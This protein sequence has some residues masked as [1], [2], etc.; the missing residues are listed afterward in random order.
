MS[1]SGNIADGQEKSLD[2]RSITLARLT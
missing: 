1:I 2:A